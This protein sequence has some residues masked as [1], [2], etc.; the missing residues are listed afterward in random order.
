VGTVRFPLEGA[1]ILSEG[2]L[3][4]IRTKRQSFPKKTP[5]RSE[6]NSISF[7]EKMG[8]L[9]SIFHFTTVN[10]PRYC[11]EIEIPLLCGYYGQTCFWYD[12]FP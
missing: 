1:E 8:A 7:P 12:K 5:V 11:S 2:N 6:Q 3:S 10:F 9:K 4:P